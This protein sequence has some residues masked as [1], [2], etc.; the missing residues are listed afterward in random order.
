MP[1]WRIMESLTVVKGSLESRRL[2]RDSVEVR[3]VAMI[4]ELD[5]QFDGDI[6]EINKV[7]QEEMPVKD[8]SG[9]Q[10]LEEGPCQETHKRVKNIMNGLFLGDG[11]KS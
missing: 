6:M 11:L 1:G 3:I 7:I 2:E 5:I 8:G 9:V 10:K 4:G